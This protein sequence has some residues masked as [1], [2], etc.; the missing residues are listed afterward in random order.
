MLSDLAGFV[1]QEYSSFSDFQGKLLD[2]LSDSLHLSSS[3]WLS[4]KKTES[5][6]FHEDFTDLDRFF[7]NWSIPPGAS[8]L[9]TP[10]GLRFSDAHFPLLTKTLA[11]LGDCEFE[12]KAR[13]EAQRVGWVVKGTKDYDSQLPRFC[14]MFN[15]AA[16]GTITPHIWNPAKGI[17][18]ETHYQVFKSHSRRVK[19]EEHGGWFTLTTRVRGDSV[20][21]RQGRRALLKVDFG[22][23]EFR[24]WYGFPN[25]QGQLGFRC[26]P[27]ERAT[28]A[29][30]RV[31]ELRTEDRAKKRLK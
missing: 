23:P 24:E 9:L 10:E 1:R 29:Y 16:G 25:K 15:L 19:I 4:L 17:N 30:V 3:K 18:P 26:H 20:E 2:W 5:A 22:K 13:I 27:T 21:I 12:F 7:I 31:R 11:L 28:I 6:E 8:F 14:A